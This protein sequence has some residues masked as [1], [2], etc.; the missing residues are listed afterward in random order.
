MIVDLDA[1]LDIGKSI[2]WLNLLCED[3]GR[4]ASIKTRVL[5]LMK[6]LRA[7]QPPISDAEVKQTLDQIAQQPMDWQ[8]HDDQRVRRSLSELESRL[9]R[10]NRLKE[11]GI[12][13]Y[14]M[15]PDIQVDLRDLCREFSQ[16]GLFF[17]P[18]GELESWVP[19]LMS[20]CPKGI[21]KTER[22]FIAASK[23]R[24]LS[25]K[26]EMY[27]SSCALFSDFVRRKGRQVKRTE[28]LTFAP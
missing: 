24:A 25:E 23:I 12:A 6:R 5:H 28:S 19:N 14:E 15:H 10:V 22:A 1:I 11:G 2:I 3:S 21:S 27:G 13:A 8:S 20:D 7:L 18:S 17:V 9:K 16:F 26:K 4:A